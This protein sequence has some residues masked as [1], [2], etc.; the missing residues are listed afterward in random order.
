MAGQ[1]VKLLD[2]APIRD[3]GEPTFQTVTPQFQ[4]G[5]TK[6]ASG[7]AFTPKIREFISS[8]QPVM[9]KIFA[10]VNAMGAGEFYGSN[11]NGDYF[12]ED[13]LRKYH[14]TFVSDGKPFMHHMNKDPDKCYGKVV[15]SDY[16][17]VMH[18]VELVIEYDCSKLEPKWSKKLKDGELVSVSM[19]CRVPF[20]VCSICNHKAKSPEDYCG[21]LK[22]SPGLGKLMP[23]GKRAFAI[24][25]EPTF[26]DISI[27]TIPADPTARI[28]LKVAS[29]KNYFYKSASERAEETGL[30]K[31]A[32]SVT[33]K[34]NTQQANKSIITNDIKANI[35]PAFSEIMQM[36]NSAMGPGISRENLDAIGSSSNDPLSL[37]KGFA[38]RKIML[39]PQE[40]QRIILV[41]S[42]R[43]DIADEL[44]DAGI[45]LENDP[46]N[47][48]SRM[49]SSVSGCDCSGM[50]PPEIASNRE[51]S[52]ENTK[53]IVIKI[54]LSPFE[55]TSSLERV[56]M[57]DDYRRLTGE[58]EIAE[59]IPSFLDDP[60]GAIKAYLAIGSMVTAFNNMLG[61]EIS[62]AML[63]GPVSTSLAFAGP[64]AIHMV[65]ELPA[66]LN[67]PSQQMFFESADSPENVERS[68]IQAVAE[69]Q[70][71][72]AGLKQAN[73]EFPR[74][75]LRSLMAIPMA[76][77]ASKLVSSEAK[78]SAEEEAAL[79]GKY[80]PGFLSHPEYSFPL[81]LPLIMK[82]ASARKKVAEYVKVSEK[83]L[84]KPFSEIYRNNKEVVDRAVGNLL[85]KKC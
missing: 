59:K 7:M 82:Y 79:T 75:T 62:P 33:K 46:G 12:P 66:A 63:A 51:M 83:H 76:F 30:T 72:M 22:S 85:F 20:D 3:S 24:N 50:L 57:S 2:F 64:A 52:P 54:M 53:R 17:D 56:A 45:V 13:V 9:D 19:G 69:V 8:I 41:S 47:L 70:A 77:G 81:M 39:R 60:I 65:K 37:L 38:Q 61:R 34:I 26:F 36:F 18:R 29:R 6:T 28:L 42:G 67:R 55:K 74:L 27:V 43:P 4:A 1:F 10:V 44:D 71:R 5:L 25:T 80:D 21:H 68:L 11:I 78:K 40:T 84:K 49:M 15:E 35:D 23:D 48:M 31:A 32:E 58:K 16:N 14:P 73:L